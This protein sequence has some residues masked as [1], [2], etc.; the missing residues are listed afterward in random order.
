MRRQTKVRVFSREFKEAA[1]KRMIAGEN[2]RAVA[3]ELQVWPKLLYDWWNLYERG[4]P[5]ARRA[6]GRPRGS[7]P[8]VVRDSQPRRR[9]AEET[10]A[11]LAVASGTERVAE[12]ERKIGPQAL[13]LDF[14][15]RALQHIRASV[16]SSDELGAKPSSS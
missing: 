5:E 11:G 14:F 15:A 9:T 16:P 2:V 1:V 13:E 3:T 4:G 6:P 10:T 7:R 12:L 8:R